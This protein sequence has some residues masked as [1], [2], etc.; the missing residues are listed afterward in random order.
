MEQILEFSEND[1]GDYGIEK[2]GDKWRVMKDIEKR[3]QQRELCA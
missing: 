3:K 2:A 1:L